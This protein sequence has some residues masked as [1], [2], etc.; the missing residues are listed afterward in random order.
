MR[1]PDTELDSGRPGE[2]GVGLRLQAL[3]PCRSR[4]D[5]EGT[6]AGPP[7]SALVPPAPRA[8]QADQ[9]KSSGRSSDGTHLR[10][11]EEDEGGDGRN[12]RPQGD[13][14][15]ASAGDEAQKRGRPDLVDSCGYLIAEY[16]RAQ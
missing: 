1:F 9:K 2:A 3:V 5:S 14:V 7:A 8:C 12:S 6:S 4:E 15:V 10:R 16:S 13:V 11:E